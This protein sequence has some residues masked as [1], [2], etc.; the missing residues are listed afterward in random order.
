MRLRL[1]S[2]SA[3]C[4]VSRGVSRAGSHDG[5]RSMQSATSVWRAVTPVSREGG[6]A[7]FRGS[8]HPAAR[9]RCPASTS[10]ASAPVRREQVAA[11]E[12]VTAG[13][14]VA[15]ALVDGERSP[16]VRAQQRAVAAG[17]PVAALADVARLG[18]DRHLLALRGGEQRAV[19][20][21][22][23]APAR[24]QVPCASRR[25]PPLRTTAR[26]RLPAWSRQAC[27]TASE[28][29]LLGRSPASR[30]RTDDTRVHVRPGAGGPRHL[31]AKEGC[32]PPVPDRL[33]RPLYARRPRFPRGLLRASRRWP[34]ASATKAP[35]RAR[36]ARSARARLLLR[37]RLHRARRA[38]S[39]SCRR[40]SRESLPARVKYST[41]RS[42]ISRPLRQTTFASRNIA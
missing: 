3:T 6:G 4:R 16:L 35:R 25:R 27:P 20:G 7:Q 31:G 30:H 26:R 32:E 38:R 33:A 40:A 37:Q 24:R 18:G 13:A 8:A 34:P 22:P 11:D 19:A 14:Q 5:S 21:R 2:A 42:R 39:A 1:R 15:L 10:R 17:Q 36:R 29:P 9:S 23:A 28:S 41:I 12:L